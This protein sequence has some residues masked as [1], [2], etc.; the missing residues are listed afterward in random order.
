MCQTPPVPTHKPR[1]LSNLPFRPPTPPPSPSDNHNE[2][3]SPAQIASSRANGA[4]S[5]GPIT[6]R[7]KRNSSLNST[8]HGFSAPDPSLDH[9][10]PAA[11]IELRDR[12]MVNL[13]P[14]NVDEAQLIQIMAVARWRQLQVIQAQTISLNEAMASHLPDSAEA[15]AR[16]VRAFET[17]PEF[18]TLH[19][20]EAAFDRH[21]SRVLR[22][23]L[24]LQSRPEKKFLAERTQQ[25]TESKET[26]IEAN[27]PN[28]APSATTIREDSVED[29]SPVLRRLLYLQSRPEKKFLA[30]RTQQTTESKT[31]AIEVILPNPAPS[32]TTTQQDSGQSS[33][34]DSDRHQRRTH[35]R[36]T[37]ARRSPSPR[38]HVLRRLK[39]LHLLPRIH[40]PDRSSSP[41][42]HIEKSGESTAA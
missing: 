36:P 39:S 37:R 25:A 23:L 12:F 41:F 38:P 32:A 24:Y 13:R 18:H 33:S 2:M 42:H 28:S 1:A 20:Y 27:L 35:P 22:R 34:A 5:R 4:R 30:K 9:D 6:A 10:P 3:R 40:S 11:F 26:P 29:S 15:T 21:S 17:A 19:R 31:T 8:R 14:R 16:I 7:G